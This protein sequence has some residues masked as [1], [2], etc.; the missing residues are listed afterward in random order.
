[1][2]KTALP[3]RAPL[4]LPVPA[5]ITLCWARRKVQMTNPTKFRDVVSRSRALLVICMININLL[6][7][8]TISYGYIDR[9]TWVQR[10]IVN[11]VHPLICMNMTRKYYVNTV[12]VE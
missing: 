7:I 2:P 1:M 5:K 9:C 10:V 8:P 3:E 12:L 11:T 4:W 6:N